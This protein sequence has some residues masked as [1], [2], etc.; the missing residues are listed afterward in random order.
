MLEIMLF[1]RPTIRHGGPNR[2]KTILDLGGVNLSLLLCDPQAFP[3]EV[4][5]NAISMP[6]L[7]L[8][9]ILHMFLLFDVIV[10]FLRSLAATGVL[11]ISN[12]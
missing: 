9:T 8:V 7:K 6:H 5:H 1:V 3:E 4:R 10:S 2:V 12:G 11:L